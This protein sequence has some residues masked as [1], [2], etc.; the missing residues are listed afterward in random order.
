MPRLTN[1]QLAAIKAAYTKSGIS[2]LDRSG[3]FLMDR[4]NQASPVAWCAYQDAAEVIAQVFG[5][6]P[7]LLADLEEA[8]EHRRVLRD[9]LRLAAAVM[10]HSKNFDGYPAV[11]PSCDADCPKCLLEEVLAATEGQNG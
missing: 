6:F 9:R 3:K 10:V 5:V 4:D 1:D 2:Q 11:K 8:R 7:A